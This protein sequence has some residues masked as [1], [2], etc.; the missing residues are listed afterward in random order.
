MKVAAFLHL[1]LRHKNVRALQHSLRI[2][3]LRKTLMTG[4][5]Y[6]INLYLHL[7]YVQNTLKPNYTGKQVDIYKG[8]FRGARERQMPFQ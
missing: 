1:H 3:Q 8:I 2:L 7:Q 6:R 5:L 4:N